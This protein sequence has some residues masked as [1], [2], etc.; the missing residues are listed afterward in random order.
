MPRLLFEMCC[1]LLRLFFTNFY[2]LRLARSCH[3]AVFCGGSNGPEVHL[4]NKR[5]NFSS[6]LFFTAS[7]LETK[8]AVLNVAENIFLREDFS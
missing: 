2:K 4:T 3:N 1:F 5:V 8:R 7:C 6:P